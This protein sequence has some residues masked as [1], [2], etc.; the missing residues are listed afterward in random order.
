MVGRPRLAH[1]AVPLLVL[2]AS[3]RAAAQQPDDTLPGPAIVE[4]R[5]GR[6]AARTVLAYRA[7]DDALIPLSQFLAL[8]E[9]GA[10]VDSGGVVRALIEPRHVPFVVDATTRTV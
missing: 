8:A 4:L 5:M 1:V 10:E 6:L 9:I 2:L 3:G 7:G